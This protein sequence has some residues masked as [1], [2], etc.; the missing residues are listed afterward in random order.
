MMVDRESHYRISVSN[1]HNGRV[2]RRLIRTQ[3]RLDYFHN[4]SLIE[5]RGQHD[6]Y[7]VLLSCDCWYIVSLNRKS[8]V[9]WWVGEKGRKRIR[10]IRM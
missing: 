2:R 5:V 1:H 7:K 10:V 4:R 3:S 9:G 6:N 8:T